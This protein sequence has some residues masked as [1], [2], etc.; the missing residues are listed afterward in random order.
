MRKVGEHN[1]NSEECWKSVNNSIPNEAVKIGKKIEQQSKKKSTN[2]DPK[3][4]I[5]T[6]KREEP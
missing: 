2:K 6:L 1:C 4:V 3:K 5:Q